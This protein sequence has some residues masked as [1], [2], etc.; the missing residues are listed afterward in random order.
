MDCTECVN[1]IPFLAINDFQRKSSWQKL[2]ED[3]ECFMENMTQSL[4]LLFKEWINKTINRVWT[5]KEY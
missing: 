4:R 1:L 2:P 3:N 5:G